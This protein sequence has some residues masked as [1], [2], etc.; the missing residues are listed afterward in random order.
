MRGR[1]LVSAGYESGL[2]EVC[3]KVGNYFPCGCVETAQRSLDLLEFLSTTPGSARNILQHHSFPLKEH[4]LL[5]MCQNFVLFMKYDI[6]AFHFHFIEESNN[7][8][9]KIVLMRKG[10]SNLVGLS[11]SLLSNLKMRRPRGDYH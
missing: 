2:I 7:A 11:F 6:R 8:T 5:T 9:G 1:T 4:K 3:Q 10:E